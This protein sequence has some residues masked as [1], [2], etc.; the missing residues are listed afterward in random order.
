MHLVCNLG[1]EGRTCKLTVAPIG[2]PL[3]IPKDLCYSLASH[4]RLQFLNYYS[5]KVNKWLENISRGEVALAMVKLEVPLSG[6]VTT[7]WGD[8]CTLFLELNFFICDFV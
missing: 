8:T 1:Q 4:G 6:R 2:D 7:V 5:G 3:S